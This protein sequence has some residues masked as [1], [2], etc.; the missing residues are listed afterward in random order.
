M[1]ESLKTIRVSEDTLEDIK[2]L[3]KLLKCR[4]CDEVVRTLIVVFVKFSEMVPRDR[5][6][7]PIGAYI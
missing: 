1:V 7:P 5:R 6:E 4:S 3:K 2:A